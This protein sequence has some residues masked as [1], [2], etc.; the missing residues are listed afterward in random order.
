MAKRQINYKTINIKMER[1]AERFGSHIGNRAGIRH[2]FPDILRPSGIVKGG[3]GLV[4]SYEEAYERKRRG[5]HADIDISG[6]TREVYE[7]EVRKFY[8]TYG[9][10]LDLRR[11]IA[12]QR[13]EAREL[14][15]DAFEYMGKEP[16]ENLSKMSYEEMRD[17]IREANDYM[18]DNHYDKT[19]SSKFY[20][21]I[22]EKLQGNG[23]AEA[24]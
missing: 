24:Q 23:D 5:T 21:R 19:Q 17:I 15:E 16:P 7:G 8:E 11:E 13:K 9:H 14:I 20:E 10:R 18:S 1:V 2:D 22:V 12:K 4:M 3:T 6:F